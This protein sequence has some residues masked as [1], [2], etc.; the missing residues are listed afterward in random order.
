[1]KK[2]KHV[3]QPD[4]PAPP[5]LAWGRGLDSL[6]TIDQ[7]VQH[8]PFDCR[9]N[10]SS[11]FCYSATDAH[12]TTAYVHCR[13]RQLTCRSC[14]KQRYRELQRH[15]ESACIDNALD[16]Y[17]VLTLPGAVPLSNRER[18]LK[19]GLSRL[20][21]D[22]R[23]VL[24]GRISYV[25]A[26]GVGEGLNLHLNVLISADLSNARV[27]GRRVRW[28]K[29]VWHRLTGSQQVS[30]QLIRE[31]THGNVVRYVL[32]DMFRTVLAFPLARRR[33]ASSKNIGLGSEKRKNGDG[34]RWV[35][36]GNPSSFY[37][38]AL[39]LDP[40]AVTNGS[41][42]H[43][44]DVDA[45]AS[46]PRGGCEVPLDGGAPLARLQAP[47]APEQARRPVIGGELC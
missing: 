12:G 1:M 28:L 5:E 33:I 18:V 6:S 4:L 31:G 19:H 30:L 37:A 47:P 7:V 15:I 2:R 25:W 38:R 39:G 43:T 42:T 46:P 32:T 23:R 36:L 16:Y 26:L 14:A 34:L 41:Y 44:P 27:Y 3:T 17:M 9:F 40:Y 21:Q 13:C 11:G 24:K 29:R 20:L 10:T 45:P 8:L 22:T 35:R